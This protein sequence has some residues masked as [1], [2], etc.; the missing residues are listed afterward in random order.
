MGLG[1]WISSP[2]AGYPG[3]YVK[4][5]LNILL[6]AGEGTYA[7]LAQCGLDMPQ[8]VVLSHAHGDHILGIPTLLLMARQKGLRL[9][10]VATPSVLDSLRKMLEAVHMPHLAQYMEAVALP[11][12][13]STQIGSTRISFAPAIH[14]VEAV[15]VRL[16]HEGRCLAYSGDT[17]PSPKLVE[18]A[19]NCDL[20]VHEVSGNPGQEEPAHAVG[21]ST[22]KD[23]LELAKAAG[24]KALLPLHFYI[25]TPLLPPSDVNVY[26]PHIC[27]SIEL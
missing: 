3:I 16:E 17:A 24:V 13:G 19:R 8:A 15:H 5:D 20:L 2:W 10:V 9:K 6:D 26:I 1:G 25:S 4:T 12:D 14:S 21:H 18:L 11:P 23:A 27:S 7:R 22:T